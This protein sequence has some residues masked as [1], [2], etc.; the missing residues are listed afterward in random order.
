MIRIGL[1][2]IL[3]GMGGNYGEAT[4]DPNMSKTSYSYKT[5]SYTSVKF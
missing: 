1:K 5:N 3:I 4:S 2:T